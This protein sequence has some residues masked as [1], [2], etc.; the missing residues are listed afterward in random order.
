MTPLDQLTDRELSEVFAV[1]VVGNNDEGHPYAT[2]A[3][4]VLPYIED[5]FTADRACHLETKPW[6]VWVSGKGPAVRARAPTFAR[7]ACIALI[8]AKRAEGADQ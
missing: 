3:D 5:G 2:S 1:E 6:D 7:A 4:A 8:L